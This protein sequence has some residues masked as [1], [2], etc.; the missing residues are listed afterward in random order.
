MLTRPI[1]VV[2]RLSDTY[3]GNGKLVREIQMN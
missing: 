3:V 2:A 1:R